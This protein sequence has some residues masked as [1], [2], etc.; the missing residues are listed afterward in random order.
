MMWLSPLTYLRLFHTFV[1]DEIVDGPALFQSGRLRQ[2]Q[3]ANDQLNI[4][5]IIPC[6][7]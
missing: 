1:D 4:V 7:D 5:G 2:L 3:T 6:R